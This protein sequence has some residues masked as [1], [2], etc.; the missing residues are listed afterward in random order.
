MKDCMCDK[1]DRRDMCDRCDSNVLERRMK[2]VDTVMAWINECHDMQER[3][4]ILDRVDGFRVDNDGFE[5][6]LDELA[7]GDE[8]E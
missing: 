8:Y 1:C 3:C 7:K 6:R 2:K 4:K 5:G